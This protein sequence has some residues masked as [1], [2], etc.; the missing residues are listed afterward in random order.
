MQIGCTRSISWSA[1]SV[2]TFSKI[3]GE[4]LVDLNI[5]RREF[6]M[7]VVP[8]EFYFQE[9]EYSLKNICSSARV[10][11]AVNQCREDPRVS[12]GKICSRHFGCTK[13]SCS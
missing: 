1:S 12:T 9:N 10:M 11:H 3:K 2:M 13:T 5:F 6:L 7:N 4:D 8:V